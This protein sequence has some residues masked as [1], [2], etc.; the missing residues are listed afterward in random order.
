MRYGVHS[1][2]DGSQRNKEIRSK[3]RWDDM[4]MVS[5]TVGAFSSLVSIL[6]QNRMVLTDVTSFSGFISCSVK[7]RV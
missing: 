1:Q 7:G 3:I 5:L 6:S 2:F 4:K